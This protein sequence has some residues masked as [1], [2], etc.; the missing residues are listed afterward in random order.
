MA[1]DLVKLLITALLIVAISELAKRSTFL[2]AILTSLPL[3]SVLAMTW[4]YI[5]TRDTERIATLAGNVF[6]LVLPSLVLF[7]SLPLLLR[8]GVNFPMSMTLSIGLTIAAYF[9]MVFVLR[10][11]GVEL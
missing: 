1:Y 4:L 7:V 8:G 10:K 3:I 2:A 6:W 9:L 11:A 5:D